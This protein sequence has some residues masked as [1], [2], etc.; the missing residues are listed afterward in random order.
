M[1]LWRGVQRL[2]ELCHEHAYVDITFKLQGGRV[3]LVEE[4]RT[5]RP[6]DIPVIDTEAHRKHLSG[7][8]D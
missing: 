6:A 7:L 8:P 2:I 1:S 5:Y 4:K 3:V